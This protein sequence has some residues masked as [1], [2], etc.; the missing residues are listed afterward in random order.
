[1]LA[2]K[3][4]KYNWPVLSFFVTASLLL[5]LS[6]LSSNQFQVQKNSSNWV[7]HTYEVKIKLQLLLNGIRDAESNARG[8]FLTSDSMFARQYLASVTAIPRE[9]EALQA[10]IPAHKEE[11]D[12]Y[13]SIRL[14]VERR[15]SE[16]N[17]A[18][19][20]YN[21]ISSQELNQLL[22]R[23]K[24]L[25]D[26]VTSQV[27]HMQN[28][29]DRLLNDRFRNWEKQEWQASQINL[30]LSVF[31]FVVLI[32]SFITMLNE[33]DHRHRSENIAGILEEKVKERTEE[34]EHKNRVLYYQ[35]EE[36]EKRNEELSSFNFI[37]NHDLKEPLRKIRIFYDR[38][39]EIEGSEFSPTAKVY[40]KKI[41]ESITRMQRLLHDVYAYTTLNIADK[42]RETDL[43]AVLEKT[44]KT[45]EEDIQKHG[46]LIEYSKL[47]RLFA[48]P[49]Q[50]EQLFHNL[51]SNSLVFSRKDVQPI[52]SISAEKVTCTKQIYDSCWEISFR[53]NGI[54]FD[55][56]HKENIFRVFKKLHQGPEYSGTGMGLA[57]CKKIVE[58]HKGVIIANSS[59]DE[60]STI[61]ILFPDN[62]NSNVAAT[63]PGQK[64][65]A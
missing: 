21:S 9:L 19:K 33:R 32:A 6:L 5:A 15:I 36:L 59:I 48:I 11:E 56:E 2:R 12:Y 1:M 40:F 65:M 49:D 28:F 3:K 31:S 4:H 14:L 61:T 44:L 63:L 8:Y 53:D 10:M 39:E 60:G 29:E 55:A 43:N 23:G 20:S 37:V 27:L 22:I 17:L 13:K 52:I 50:M 18:F 38:I 45:L 64:M 7:T 41:N 35:N 42:F 46:A 16:L 26:I 34:V 58:N 57:I 54:G 30:F 47:P 24:Y 51:L 25:S 62:I